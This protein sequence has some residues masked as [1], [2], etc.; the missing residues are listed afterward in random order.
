MR[1]EKSAVHRELQA[2][3]EVIRSAAGRDRRTTRTE[4]EAR[5]HRL[6]A[7]EAE[8]VRALFDYLDPRDSAAG[9][10]VGGD[11]LDKAVAFAQRA[12]VDVYD[13]TSKIL[14]DGSI[15]RMSRAGQL[16]S[17]LA[18][19]RQGTPPEPSGPAGHLPAERERERSY[20]LTGAEWLTPDFFDDDP[21]A[22]SFG[23]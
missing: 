16:A 5:V 18:L 1:I 20:I 19:A 6:P 23:E 14:L 13:P 2:A 22:G 21:P 3:G 7:A 10:P 12:L 8:L 11:Q 9:L 17:V 4:L 15:S